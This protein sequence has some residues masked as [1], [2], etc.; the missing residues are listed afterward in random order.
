MERAEQLQCE[1]LQLFTRN[2][3]QWKSAPVSLAESERFY[4]AR[5][6]SNIKNVVSHASY[7][8]NLAGAPDIRDKSIDALIAEVERCDQLGID[9]VVLHP[10]A[11]GDQGASE[12]LNLL[13]EALSLVLERTDH[14]SVRLLLETM[15][16]QGTSFGSKIEEFSF[17][18]DL[19]E[20]HPRIHLC[21]DFCHVFAAGYEIR[22][23]EGYNRFIAV[24]EKHIGLSRIACW[25]LSDSKRSKGERRD[26]HEHIGAGEI[27]LTPFAL[28]VTDSRFQ[29]IPAVLETPK[30]GV[31]DAGNLELL[32]KI[33]GY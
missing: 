18:L 16:G 5:M 14:T 23:E 26:R 19:L 11:C 2:Q 33:R 1:S 32:R 8:I 22:T 4:R 15:A 17:L 31:G 21:I 3:L 13:G 9:D 25:H 10:G 24:L 29:T 7:L 27:G 30:N 28:L 12:G 20:N 6:E